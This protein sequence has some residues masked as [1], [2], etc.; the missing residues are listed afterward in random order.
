[1]ISDCGGVTAI[2]ELQ[3]HENKVVYNRALKILEHYL[4]GEEE[5][6][7]AIA[8]NVV[9]G[10]AGNQQFGFGGQGAPPQGGAANGGSGGNKEDFHF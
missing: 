6:A 4:G 10:A 3:A 7:T 5:D 2:E 8:P 9:T 1:M